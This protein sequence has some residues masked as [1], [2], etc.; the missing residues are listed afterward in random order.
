MTSVALY[1]AVDRPESRGRPL[2]VLHGL[3]GSSRNWASIGPVLAQD[4]PVHRVDLR[5]HGNSPWASHQTFPGMMEDLRGW[6]QKSGLERVHLLGHSLGGKVAMLFACRH[7]GSVASLTVVDIAPRSYPLRWQAE[8][9]ALLKLDPASLLSRRQ[10][11]E[12]LAASVPDT[13]LRLFL[14]SNLV[15][16][17]EAPGFRWRVNL[18]VLADAL[19]HLLGNPLAPSDRFPGPTRFFRGERSEFLRPS[20]LVAIRQTFPAA[21]LHSIP[22]AGHNP[23]I[24]APLPFSTEVNRFLRQADLGTVPPAA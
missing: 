14:L 6:C 18:P 16:R 2:V 19:A 8:I 15:P 20:D 11:D 7:P 13:P 1:S 24:D 21:S 17:E 9:D 12:L 22:K 3:L 5:N 4:R 23:H 10:A